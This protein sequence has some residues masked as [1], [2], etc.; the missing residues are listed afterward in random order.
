[1]KLLSKFPKERVPSS[2]TYKNLAYVCSTTAPLD[3]LTPVENNIFWTFSLCLGDII[4]I[5]TSR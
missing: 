1:M 4:R 3:H 5:L 2:H